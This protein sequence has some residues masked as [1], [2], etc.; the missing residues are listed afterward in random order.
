[1]FSP[2]TQPRCLPTAGTHRPAT[3]RQ[4]RSARLRCLR[5]F[6]GGVRISGI[7]WRQQLCRWR[8]WR[9]RRRLLFT[10]AGHVTSARDACGS[11]LLRALAP[12]GREEANSRQPTNLNFFPRSR[13]FALCDTKR[14]K[15]RTSPAPP[16]PPRPPRPPP[17]PPSP[18]PPAENER[19]TD[20][21]LG[22]VRACACYPVGEGWPAVCVCVRS[23]LSL[24]LS[25]VANTAH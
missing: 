1:M 22:C 10:D 16:P 21:L 5:L 15:D 25:F 8:W 4:P 6:I 20:C 7:G 12:R 24:A 18:P 9:Q 23:S 2:Q 3:T 11:F 17:P 13:F 14:E 19:R